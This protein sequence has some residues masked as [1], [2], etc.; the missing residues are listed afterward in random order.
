MLQANKDNSSITIE[1]SSIKLSNEGTIWFSFLRFKFI[2]IVKYN[3][4][5]SSQ[6]PRDGLKT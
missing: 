3:A 1:S 2:K 6:W 5:L 4:L